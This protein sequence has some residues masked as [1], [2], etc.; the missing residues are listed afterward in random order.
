MYYN[1][2]NM[3]SK[4]LDLNL[5]NS[6]FLLIVGISGN[7]VA[8]TL[9][10]KTQK[11]LTENMLS[12]HFVVFCLIYFALN[13]TTDEI[14][15][16]FDT[17]KFSFLIWIFFVL[18]TRM[19][20]EFTIIVFVLAAILYYLITLVDYY[21]IDKLKDRTKDI[22]RVKRYIHVLKYMII[23]FILIGFVLYFMK[24]YNEKNEDWSINKFIFGVNVCDSLKQN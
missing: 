15:N 14:K 11:L 12:K 1:C 20:I 17:L 10:C 21:K 6:V 16:P 23:I 4:D 2:N 3:S 8:E 18:F 22:E 13:F 9:G 24:Q 7:F 5:I 19:T